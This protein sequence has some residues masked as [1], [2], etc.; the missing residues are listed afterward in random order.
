MNFT[1]ISTSELAT[2]RKNLLRFASIH[3]PNQSDF[4]EDL[5]QET[6]LSAYK[7]ANDFRGEAQLT[8][9]LISILKNKLIDHFRQQSSQN[10]VFVAP[11]AEEPMDDWFENFFAE[12]GHWQ[13]EDSPS[14]WQNPEQSLNTK[15]FY[16]ILQICLYGLPEHISRVFMM[17]E[18]LGLESNEIIQKCHI[19][20]ANFHT[21]MHRAREGL[22]Q[23]LQIKWF[24]HKELV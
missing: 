2:I 13:R 19:T 14:T 7:S 5:V 23:C 24:N 20:R 22:R 4:A 11:A 10:A 1:H 8:S 18:I 16:D 3:L 21:T 17:S 6:L 15:E 12:D 9:W